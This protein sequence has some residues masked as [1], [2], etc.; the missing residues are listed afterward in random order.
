MVEQGLAERLKNYG[1]G[2]A[3]RILNFKICEPAMGSGA[4]LIEA[5]RQLG[6]KYLELKKRQTGK[7]IEPTQYALELRRVQHFITTRNVYGVDLNPLAVDFGALSLWL[8]VIHTL[9]HRTEEEDETLPV[10]CATPWMGLRLRAGNSLIGCRRA[11]WTREQLVKGMHVRN[12]GPAP[13]ILSPGELRGE[14]EVYHFL[15]FDPEMVPASRDRLM[16][17]FY[18][19]SCDRAG[20]WHQEEVKIKWTDHEVDAALRI[21]RVMDRQWAA[22]SDARNQALQET[23][24]PASV[25]PNPIPDNPQNNMTL[26]GR[27]EIRARLE[28]KSS[29][30]QR[31]KLIMDAWCGLWYWPLEQTAE[32]PTRMAW[33]ACV[34]LL[35]NPEPPDAGTAQMMSAALG[36]DVPSFMVAVGHDI[37]N[38]EQMADAVPWL[39]I[40]REIAEVAH[41]HHWELVFPEILGPKPTH[42]GFDL[43]LGNPPWIKV[44]WQDSD[45]LAEIDPKLGVREAKSAT[46]NRKRLELLRDPEARDRYTEQFRKSEGDGG[47]LNGRRTYPELLGVQTNLFKNF[48]ARS[49][50][51]VGNTGIVGLL[52]PEGT[53]DD[54]KGGRLR[55]KIYQRL[56]RHFQFAN[57][58]NL[59]KDVDHHTAFGINIYGGTPEDT[60]FLHMSNLYHP[61]TVFGSLKHDQPHDPVLGIKDSEGKWQTRPHQNRV[62]TIT[63]K[64]LEIFAQL[65]EEKDTPAL[66]TRLPQMHANEIISVVEKL[67][68]APR[69]LM[70]LKGDY[71]STE[72]FHEANS[73]RDGIITREEEPTFHPAS[74]DEWVLSG[75]HFYVG[76]PLNK[77]PRNAC[78][79][80]NA[81]DDID[82]TEIPENY[83]P[84]A[85]YRPGNA[86][87]DL[88]AFYSAIAEWPKPSL[89]G[90]WPVADKTELL[91]WEVLL[92]EKP[93]V[94]GIDP[95]GPG[96]RTARRFICL[97]EAEGKIGKI[98]SW[99]RRNPDENDITR[100]QGEMGSFHFLQMPESE[101]DHARLPRPI[102]SYYRYVN[103]RRCSLSTERSLIPTIIPPGSAHIHPVLS[104][105]FSNL[106]VLGL[107]VSIAG[108]LTNDFFI[109][110]SGKSDIYGSTLG[111]ISLAAPNYEKFL[112]AR[113]LRLNCLTQAYSDLWGEVAG[114]WIQ[115]EQWTTDDPRLCHAVEHPWPDLD[116]DRWDWNPPLR[117]DFARRQALLE[118]DVLT[119]QALGLTFEE[120]LTIYRVQFPVMRQYE[121]V[122]EYDA[123]GRHIPNTARKNQG[124]TDFRDAR[125]KHDGISPLTVSWEIDNGNRTVT[126]AFY[127][128]FTQV[129]REA[130]YER[131]W[132]FFQKRNEN[133][134]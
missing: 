107:F 39:G 108:A 119:A 51:L 53:Y 77:T 11:V 4:F 20:K 2:D 117:S 28:A 85:V 74:P 15:V 92:G 76:T 100:I 43:V 22:Y 33:L 55:E 7:I 36:F 63:Q 10:P 41:F 91:S 109:R 19:A 54:A 18:K 59:F 83:L 125:E 111:S 13:K 34:E 70:D 12:D 99:M 102:T 128:P 84:R 88:R 127:P 29:A 14:D 112:L 61:N 58:L 103:R 48:F 68:K 16:R 3:D 134:D 32:L 82:L 56:K 101:V 25:W 124:A 122:D 73:Q 78:T 38:A 72:M 116:P 49:W 31:I 17:G 121:A 8:N 50:G 44:G 67:A 37:P 35:L 120:L 21:C 97:A 71:F 110:V 6:E 40:S 1:P 90:F 27:E 86:D 113:G 96:A 23:D 94:Y 69:R 87:G 62:I 105:T 65:L 47:F 95:E 46:Y 42:D 118:I 129:D 106:R 132:R 81:Y 26:S 57:E 75:P 24:V 66:Q 30:F 52:H 130:D 60:Q 126:Q 93:R 64:E 89:P 80:N 79:H 131:A 114:P 115:D 133:I 45:V 104:L 98:L 5:T 9:S 123:K